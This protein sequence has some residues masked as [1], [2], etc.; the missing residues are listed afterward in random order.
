MSSSSLSS[1]SCV[2]AWPAVGAA[3]P[4]RWSGTSSSS[5]LVGTA[6]GATAARVAGGTCTVMRHRCRRLCHG[7]PAAGRAWWPRPWTCTTTPIPSRST[8]DPSLPGT[9][10]G[11]AGNSD[12]EVEV[13]PY[14]VSKRS[15]SSAASATGAAAGVGTALA[16]TGA[17]ADAPGAAPYNASNSSSSM[18]NQPKKQLCSHMFH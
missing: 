12:K 4:G 14:S 9:A 2:C 3:A 10:R 15:P 17:G 13:P 5:A 1:S 6:D 11:L 18:V 16:G 8:P 7:M